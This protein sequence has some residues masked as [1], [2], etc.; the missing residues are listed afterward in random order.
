VAYQQLQSL[1]RDPSTLTPQQ[2]AE[3]LKQ[4]H[5][6]KQMHAS[7]FNAPVPANYAYHRHQQQNNHVTAVDEREFYPNAQHNLHHLQQQ[8]KSPSQYS[9]HIDETA[10]AQREYEY[11][12]QS[13]QRKLKSRA[14]STAKYVEPNQ[15]TKPFYNPPHSTYYSDPYAGQNAK[16]SSPAPLT[17]IQF[18]GNAVERQNEQPEQVQEQQQQQQQQQQ[19]QQQYL[20]QI[21][22]QWMIAQR[23]RQQQSIQNHNNQQ[24][25]PTRPIPRVAVPNVNFNDKI[26]GNGHHVMS[27]HALQSAF[28]NQHQHSELY[29]QYFHPKS[30]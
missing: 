15:L 18:Q 3:H 28:P 26:N 20:T 5:Q 23:Q 21:Q 10:V 7:A 13:L 2:Y 6:I 17:P 16:K 1:H 27:H 30:F 19:H 9:S 14:K 29:R 11:E 4:I 25:Q 8:L 12:Q 22:Y 24:Q